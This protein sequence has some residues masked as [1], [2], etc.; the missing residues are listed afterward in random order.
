MV[1]GII[2]ENTLLL[3]ILIIDGFLFKSLV[4]PKLGG[5]A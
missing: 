1:N 2:L 5:I 4:D 3:L